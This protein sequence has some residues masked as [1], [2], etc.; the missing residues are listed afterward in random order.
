MKKQIIISISRELGSGGHDIAEQIAGELG[1]P[2]YDRSLLREIAKDMNMDVSELQAYDEKP[3]NYILTRRVGK[4]SNSME[5]ILAEKQFEFI[6]KKAG[7][8]ES[9]VIVG[10]CA[11]TVLREYDGLISIFIRGDREY[12]LGRIMEHYQLN[13]E[14]A[15]EKMSKIDR[16]RRQFHNRYS[17]HKWGDANFYDVCINSSHLG[18]D[19]TAKILREY[20]DARVKKCIV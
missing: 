3:K 16:K 9:F 19:G 20:I 17:D 13:E 4:Y 18:V 6:R 15:Q 10:R 5:D 12:K 11:E 7:E 8:G 1:V 2:M 14:E